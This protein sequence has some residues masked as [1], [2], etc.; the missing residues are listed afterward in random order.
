[1]SQAADRPQRNLTGS[2]VRGHDKIALLESFAPP[3]WK[4]LRAAYSVTENH[5]EGL[6][7]WFANKPVKAGERRPTLRLLTLDQMKT[8]PLQLVAQVAAGAGRIVEEVLIDCIIQEKQLRELFSLGENVRVLG[9]RGDWDK[10][11]QRCKGFF[12]RCVAR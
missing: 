3:G 1:M 2:H 8:L 9:V 10:D 6:R 4:F 12:L 7:V 5:G 11:T